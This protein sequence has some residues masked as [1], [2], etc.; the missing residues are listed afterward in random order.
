MDP[1]IGALR[2]K[3]YRDRQLIRI[4]IAQLGRSRP[5]PTLQNPKHPLRLLCRR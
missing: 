1:D 2:R 3:N 4:A 5:V